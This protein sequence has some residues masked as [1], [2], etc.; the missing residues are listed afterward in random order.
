MDLPYKGGYRCIL[1]KIL[2]FFLLFSSFYVC[3]PL[4]SFP[5]QSVFDIQ[6]HYNKAEYA[7]QDHL[8]FPHQ[9]AGFEMSR[10]MA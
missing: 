7:S 9:T 8:Q 1:K 3:F 4:I 2:F 10:R 5:S 6:E